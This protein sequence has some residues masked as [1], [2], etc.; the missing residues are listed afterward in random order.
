MSL[1]IYHEKQTIQSALCGVHCLNSLLQRPA[2]T[3]FDLAKIAKD[4]DD[5][6]REIMAS[7]GDTK[8][9]KQF[10]KEDSSNVGDDGNFS[11]QVLEAA[12]QKRNLH[13][14]PLTSNNYYSVICNLG[15]ENA[16]ICN[17]GSHWFSIRKVLPGEWY[18]FN[19]LLEEPIHMPES[20]LAS[21]LDNLFDKKDGCIY[22]VQGTLPSIS[23]ENRPAGTGRWIVANGT[24][25]EEFEL[26]V[27]IELSKIT[28]DTQGESKS[29]GEIS[30]PKV[31]DFK[32]EDFSYPSLA[33]VKEQ[34]LPQKSSSTVQP[35]SSSTIPPSSNVQ[36]QSTPKINTSNLSLEQQISLMNEYFSRC[37][38]NMEKM[39][40]R[41]CLL[42]KT[43][44]KIQSRRK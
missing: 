30:Y 43:F 35:S 41:L 28:A 36:T 23:P 44:S 7:A 11:L 22:R 4:L 29:E 21:F 18:D 24:N 26:K 13:C 33:Q 31:P 14:T 34:P 40:D 20:H 15:Q 9:Y 17:R 6:E 37:V 10:L 27:A 2:F 12:L 42:E 39:D 25:R 3:P 32:N 5:N 8:E 19:S 1:Y 38:E 16:F